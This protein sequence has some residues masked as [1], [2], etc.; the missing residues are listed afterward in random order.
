MGSETSLLVVATAAAVDKGLYNVFS[1]GKTGEEFVFFG[2]I[3]FGKPNMV[4]LVLVEV[5]V[6][7]AVETR[8]LEFKILVVEALLLPA[9]PIRLVPA[10]DKF[11]VLLLSSGTGS[12]DFADIL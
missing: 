6:E 9:L 5:G 8:L 3:G 11:C 1:V 7:A 12:I 10:G 2:S 4:P